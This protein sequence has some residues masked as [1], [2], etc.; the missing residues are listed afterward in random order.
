MPQLHCLHCRGTMQLTK[1]LR[2]P[3]G[4]LKL[5]YECTLCERARVEAPDPDRVASDS[6]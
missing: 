3:D 4:S 6:P 5:V 2:F 1:R